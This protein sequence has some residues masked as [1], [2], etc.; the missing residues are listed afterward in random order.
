MKGWIFQDKSGTGFVSNPVV[1]PTCDPTKGPCTTQPCDPTKGQC[2][3]DPN[4]CPAGTVCPVNPPPTSFGRPFVAGAAN[5]RMFV[6]NKLQVRDGEY[7]FVSMGGRVYRAKNDSVSASAALFPWCGQVILKVELLPMKDE[8]DMSKQARNSDSMGMPMSQSLVV[9]MEDQ[10]MAGMPSML[11]KARD[12]YGDIHTGVLVV[13]MRPISLDYGKAGMQC[14]AMNGPIVQN[15]CD[16]TKGPCPIDTVKCDPTR[17]TCTQPPPC[18]PATQNCTQPPPCDP[19]TQNCTQPTGGQPPLYLGAMDAVKMAITQAGGTIGVIKDSTGAFIRVQVNLASLFKDPVMQF[20]II[21]D[22][23]GVNKFA[24]IADPM[25]KNK[26]VLRENLPMAVPAPGQ[27]PVNNPPPDTGTVV[28]NPPD[29]TRPPV[30]RGTLENLQMVLN[31]KNWNVVIPTPQGPIQVLLNKTS[32]HLDGTVYVAADAG[33]AA[34]LFIFMGDKLDPS[35]PA[36]NAAGMLMVMEKVV[37]A[38]P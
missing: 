23:N 29:S 2:P 35:K 37:T 1:Q 30:Y 15:P 28:T 8:S 36:L 19:A 10:F 27:P 3:V 22:A 34:R 20:V 17:Q 4:Q 24:F 21:A 32:L 5:Y 11:D 16:P 7:F 31:E 12:S 18:D 14:P 13:E 25:D 38:G 26:L 9:A 6:T 33:N